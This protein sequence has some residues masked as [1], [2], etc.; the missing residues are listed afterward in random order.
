MKKILL[1]SLFLIVSCSDS[2]N[3][4]FEMFTTP[5]AKD[6]YFSAGGTG[7]HLIQSDGIILTS[8]NP[9]VQGTAFVINHKTCTDQTS[10]T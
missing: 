2:G 4:F 3:T 6:L 1:L 8:V 10:S 7:L 5:T 9:T